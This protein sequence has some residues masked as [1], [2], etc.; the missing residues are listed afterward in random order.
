MGEGVAKLVRFVSLSFASLGNHLLAAIK[1]THLT[2]FHSTT[3]HKTVNGEKRFSISNIL[4]SS[5]FAFNPFCLCG[6]KSSR[7]RSRSAF[8]LFQTKRPKTVWQKLLSPG[9]T[10][11]CPKYRQKYIYIFMYMHLDGRTTRNTFNRF[12]NTQLI[13]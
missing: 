9:R 5:V 12:S 8:S 10:Y 3:P 2:A 7:S 11:G 13:D 4:R 1:S 6:L